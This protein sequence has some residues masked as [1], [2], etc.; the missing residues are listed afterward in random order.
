MS[1][2]RGVKKAHK[3]VKI[4]Q[5]ITLKYEKHLKE[6]EISKQMKVSKRQLDRYANQI[7]E[8]MFTDE[9]KLKMTMKFFN[10]WLNRIRDAE[11]DY[12]NA[13]KIDK[14]TGEEIIDKQA[15][16]QFS[17]VLND[18]LKEAD[19]FLSKASLLDSDKNIIEHK[20]SYKPEDIKESINKILSKE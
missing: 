8:V 18:T 12:N 3:L 14:R 13:K 19:R 15:R 10:I 17:K 16:A 9:F 2:I 5:Y 4:N 1:K 20:I 7:P 6:E 11:T